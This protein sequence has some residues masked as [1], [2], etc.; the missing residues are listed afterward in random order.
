MFSIVAFITS[1][2]LIFHLYKIK[3][4]AKHDDHLFK[5]CALRREVMDYL[6][7]NHHEISKTE[8]KSIK[9]LLKVI[10]N[11]IGLYSKHK[12]TIFNLRKFIKYIN[13]TKNLSDSSKKITKS[14]NKTINNFHN[15]LNRN[16]IKAFFGYTP[17]L[18][19]EICLRLLPKIISILTR[20]GL[21]ELND[22][23]NKL[24]IASKNFD[25]INADRKKFY[26]KTEFN[27]DTTKYHTK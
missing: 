25:V 11:N 6:R 19:S 21:H 3:L 24:L 17:F 23:N 1:A 18:Y 8:Y 13:N 4:S 10:N 27:N 5:F 2:S 9:Q 26:I 14:K 12:A 7:I 20:T 22:F 15:D 16:I